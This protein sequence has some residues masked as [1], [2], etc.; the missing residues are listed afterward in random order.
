MLSNEPTKSDDRPKVGTRLRGV[1]V[2][3]GRTIPE[4]VT[5]L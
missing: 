4:T 2:I 1:K 5:I 3:R